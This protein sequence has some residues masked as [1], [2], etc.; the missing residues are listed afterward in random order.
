[1]RRSRKL[2]PVG[3]VTMVELVRESQ[4]DESKSARAC[5]G[6]ARDCGVL[7]VCSSMMAPAAGLLPSMPSEPAER[8]AMGASAGWS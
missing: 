5:C 1:M 3:P 2:W 8:A 4:V 6:D 7:M